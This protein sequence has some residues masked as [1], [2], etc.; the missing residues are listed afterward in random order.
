MKHRIMKHRNNIKFFKLAIL[1]CMVISISSCASYKGGSS[2]H[3]SL[4]N[5][6]EKDLQYSEV[7]SNLNDFIGTEVRWGGEI[8]KVERLD[9]QARVTMISYPIT[10]NGKPDYQR[11]VNS[12]RRGRFIIDVSDELADKIF[13]RNKI[14]TVFGSIAGSEVAQ[15]SKAEL[16]IPVIKAL[17]IKHWFSPTSYSRNVNDY[18]FY[19]HHYRCLK[20]YVYRAGYHYPVGGCHYYW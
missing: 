5:A 12:E 18:G 10:D 11:I 19:R 17:E 13:R 15:V 4:V 3:S 8:L 20:P 2:L 9:S 14:L 16:K 7:I 1:F 6:P